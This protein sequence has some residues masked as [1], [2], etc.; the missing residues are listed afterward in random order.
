MSLAEPTNW[1]R[2]VA[3]LAFIS[4]ILSS[5]AASLNELVQIYPP[6]TKYAVILA[7][8]AGFVASITERIQGGASK[9]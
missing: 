8:I 2:I 6:A 1:S 7:I 9:K 5:A 4:V 3:W